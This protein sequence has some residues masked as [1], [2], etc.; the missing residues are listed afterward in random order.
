MQLLYLGGTDETGA[1]AA[2]ARQGGRTSSH[3][4]VVK[5]AA[6]RGQLEPHPAGNRWATMESPRLRMNSNKGGGNWGIYK[7]IPERH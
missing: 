2:E 1:E 6:T 5:L 4:Y 7:A 3:G